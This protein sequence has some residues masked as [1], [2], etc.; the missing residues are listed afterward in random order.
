[1]VRAGRVDAVLIGDDFPELGADLVAALAGLDVNKFPHGVWCGGEEEVLGGFVPWKR[2][3]REARLEKVV[4]HVIG[5]CAIQKNA[6]WSC[7]AAS[8]HSARRTRRIGRAQSRVHEPWP[9]K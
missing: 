1:M 6:A 5:V 8:V 2:A 9:T 4:A 3:V 7:M